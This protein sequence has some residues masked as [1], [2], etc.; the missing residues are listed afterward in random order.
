MRILYYD[1]FCGISGDMNLGA[2]I[3]LG[4]D[5]EHLKSELAKLPMANEFELEIF[6]A[7]K[8]GIE[9]T[10]V[11]VLLKTGDSQGH[12]GHRHL[13]DHDHSGHHH[14]HHQG[15]SHS[16]SHN[17][18]HQGHR[19]L[20][21]LD[22]SGH[23]HL[24]DHSGHHHRNLSHIEALIDNSSLSDSV[25]A[26][27]KKIFMEVAVAEAKVH[28]KSLEEVH[29]HE[30]GAVDSIVDIVGAAICFE[31]LSVDKVMSSS[32]ELGGGFVK[33]D[34]GMMPVP[35]PATAEILKGVPVKKGLVD[36]EMTTPTG[37]AILKALVS[38][39]SDQLQ[40]NVSKIGYGLGTRDLEFPNVL[41]VMLL[42]EAD[43][44]EGLV[45]KNS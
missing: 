17:H 30:V 6:K 27:S 41:R 36:K 43:S 2:L 12:Q 28:G 13:D 21:D 5:P 31:A 14:H 25:K 35:A 32:V 26:L 3:D 33:C 37:A 38:V 15:H 29:F 44:K 39:Y 9:G 40:M 42:T 20:D 34:H 22:H 4:V 10:K 18:S 8:K 19:H 45:K 16:H 7:Q 1:C 23:R 11:N 24:D